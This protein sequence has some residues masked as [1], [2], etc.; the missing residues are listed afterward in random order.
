MLLSRNHFIGLVAI[1]GDCTECIIDTGGARTM[2]DKAT[3]SAAGLSITLPGEGVEVGGYY[4]PS[5]GDIIYYHGV[6]QGPVQLRFSEDVVI[7]IGELKVL[8]STDP[9][10]LIGADAMAA[11]LQARCP[12]WQ[13]LHIGYGGKDCGASCSFRVHVAWFAWC[14][15]FHGQCHPRRCTRKPAG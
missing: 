14:L 1:N 13:F 11:P 9:M 15:L 5:G 6:V 7:S 3:A 4:Q 12:G 2:L 10:I 8:E